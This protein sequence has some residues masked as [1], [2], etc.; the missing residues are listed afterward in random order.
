MIRPLTCLT[1]LVACGSGLYLYQSKHQVQL[2]DRQIEKAVHETDAL[3]EQSRA[4]RAEWMLLNDP[5]RLRQFA[6]EYLSL[7]PIMPTQFTSMAE[8]DS[9][10][11]PPT[12]N[13]PPAEVPV[14]AASDAV[15]PDAAT[16]A[17][18][19]PAT[20]DADA[21]AASADAPAGAATADAGGDEAPPAVADQDLPVPPLPAAPTAV[22]SAPSAPRVAEHKSTPPAAGRPDT[23][24]A[25]V[26][27]QA[28]PR[29]AR[30]EP[31]RQESRSPEPR[32]AEAR[33]ATLR[34]IE[35]RPSETR[36]AAAS[37]S[38]PPVRTSAPLPVAHPMPSGGSLLGM[39][40]GANPPVPLPRPTPVSV[41]EW[42]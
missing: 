3:R 28:E 25:S 16:V 38:R 27:R 19:A 37:P 31:Q 2:L 41:N 42:N 15:P 40:R 7:K 30:A 33:P 13:P 21:T 23:A 8:L 22:A 29:S 10:L 34:P 20:A 6:D 1:F 5:E 4:L 35:L 11:P 9:R 12:P 17:A 14:A 39:A 26:P 24:V 36:T 18:A 32:V